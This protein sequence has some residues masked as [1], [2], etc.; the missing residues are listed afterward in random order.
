VPLPGALVATDFDIT[1]ARD[2]DR[3]FDLGAF[4]HAP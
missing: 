2:R 3:G 4:E 1:T